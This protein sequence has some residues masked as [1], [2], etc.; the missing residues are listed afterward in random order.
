MII[1]A[2]FIPGISQLTN[3]ENNKNLFKATQLIVFK[4]DS[5][6]ISRVIYKSLIFFSETELEEWPKGVR[7]EI[8]LES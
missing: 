8:S 6:I 5:G 4:S 3:I 2:I 7:R 1:L